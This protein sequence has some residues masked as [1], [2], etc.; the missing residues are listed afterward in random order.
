MSFGDLLAKQAIANGL[1]P[2][3]AGYTGEVPEQYRPA[4]QQPIPQTQKQVPPY[5]GATTTGYTGATGQGAAFQGETPLP[6][7]VTAGV[8]P[9]SNTPYNFTG[10]ADMSPEEAARMNWERDPLASLYKSWGIP[11]YNANVLDRYRVSQG[12]NMLAAYEAAKAMGRFGGGFSQYAAEYNPMQS[13]DFARDI[14]A[15]MGAG[16]QGTYSEQDANAIAALREAGM[17]NAF[18]GMG[19]TAS[20]TP[21]F[22]NYRAGRQPYLESMWNVSPELWGG[23][24]EDKG[25]EYDF[26]AYERSK[27]GDRYGIA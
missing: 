3:P 21:A 24:G 22:A 15:G 10:A 20:M 11:D 5:L 16:P 17:W 6:T 26:L 19:M 4:I 23:H 7:G 2:P 14:Y 12:G 9:Y 13:R 27:Y 25:G 8:P 18:Q 1:I